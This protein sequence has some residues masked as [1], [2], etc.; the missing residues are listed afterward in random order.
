[1]TAAKGY[2]ALV[3][4]RP[5]AS[6]L[7]AANIGVILLS[8]EH[9]FLQARFAEGHERIRR[10]F[11]PRDWYLV[12]MQRQA[13]EARLATDK[14]GL[15]TAD[16]LR[17]Y[18]A[19][20]ANEV[21]ITEP[22]YVRVEN[23]ADE[24]ATLFERLVGF[25]RGKRRASRAVSK[26][27]EIVRREKLADVLETNYEVRLP[28]LKHKLVAPFAYKNGHWNLIEPQRFD[29]ED[30]EDSFDKACRLRLYAEKLQA[31]N[32]G[33]AARGSLIVVAQFA[34]DHD[35]LRAD[36]TKMLREEKARLYEFDN[37]DPLI[38][39]IRK[40]AKDRAGAK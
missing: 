10:F 19:R 30:E 13:V 26:F 9:R 28:G 23:P 36:V 3:Q 11:G 14:D 32:T 22:R 7:E 25:E 18:A 38:G 20:L 35:A 12:D 37:L 17:E 4:Y 31:A 2:Y 1:M 15:R 29:L 39:E 34:P 27:R 8:P 5:D 6:R 16:D 40:V 21:L 33:A 24:L